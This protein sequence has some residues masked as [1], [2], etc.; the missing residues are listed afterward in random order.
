[1]TSL[2]SDN[3]S[4]KYLFL[5]LIVAAFILGF[6]PVA[7]KLM[8]RWDSGD[9]SYCYLILPLFLYLSWEKRTEFHFGQLSWNLWGLVPVGL[10]LVMIIAGELS[11]VETGLYTGVWICIVGVMFVLYGARLRQLIFPIL[12]L[13]FIVPMPPFVNSMLTFNLKLMAS[14]LATIMLRL[15]GFSV[16][17]DGNIIDLGVTQMQVVDAC[18]GL[19]YLM[20]LILMALLFGYFYG[21]R[22]WQK[23]VLLALVLPLSIVVNG[24]RIFGTGMLYVW[25]YPEMAEDFFHDFSGWLVFMTAA[26]ILFGTSLLLR[27]IGSGEKKIPLNDP[28]STPTSLKRQAAITIAICL[29]FTGSGWAL[30]K[31]PAARN[32]PDRSTFDSFPMQIG[33][34]SAKRNYLSDEILGSLWADDYVSAIYQRP[35]SLNSIQ[36]LIP[37][38][39]YQGTR[40]TAHAPQSCMLGSGW[41][42][43]GSKE[44]LVDVGNGEQIPMSLSVWQKGEY[45][46]CGAYFFLM[47]GRVITSPWAN[48]LHLII[49]AVTKRRTDGALVR[50]EVVVAPG[51]SVEDVKAK[52]EEFVKEL[53]PILPSYVPL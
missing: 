29:F 31:L 19:R 35:G 13:A 14:G 26:G 41:A 4:F 52:I 12:I 18:S 11:S 47:R 38:Y 33:Q 5:G 32:L 45:R 23:I 49:D 51:Q 48:K 39:N 43:T 28:G 46:V 34:W 40:H 25:G 24:L 16:L 15:A 3:K 44:R 17:Q 2:I 37:F 21:Q 36:L 10:S 20:P 9:N 6:Y 7:Q 8:M 22:L 50:M 1:M 27:R 42:L 53:W 30:Q